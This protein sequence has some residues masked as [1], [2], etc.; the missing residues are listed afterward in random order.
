MAK[1]EDVAKHAFSAAMK[2][3]LLAADEIL[4]GIGDESIEF[5]CDLG[6]LEH[7]IRKSPV[8]PIKATFRTGTRGIFRVNERRYATEF[9]TRGMTMTLGEAVDLKIAFQSRILA[10]RRIV[11]MKSHR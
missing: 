8:F 10:D 7:R 4:A 1:S 11:A 5:R 6:R 3:V 2:S 9:A